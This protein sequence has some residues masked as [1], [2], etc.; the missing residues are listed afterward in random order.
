MT[1]PLPPADL[2]HLER[3]ISEYSPAVPTREKTA[4]LIARVLDALPALIAAARERD[5]LRAMLVRCQW[6]DSRVRCPVCGFYRGSGHHPTC[7][8]ALAVAL[9]KRPIVSTG[10]EKSL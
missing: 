3:K 5:A 2:D 4:E 7:A 6:A 8:L 1:V 9:G 10:Q